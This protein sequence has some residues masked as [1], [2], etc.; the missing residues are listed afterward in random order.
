MPEDNS[1]VCTVYIISMLIEVHCSLY[2]A[3]TLTH[4][5]LLYKLFTHPV[6]PFLIIDVS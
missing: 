1:F 3:L 6:Q 4:T 2:R 5:L